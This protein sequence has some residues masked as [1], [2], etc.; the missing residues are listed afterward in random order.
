M[1]GNTLRETYKHKTKMIRPPRKASCTSSC[2]NT[3]QIIIINVLKAC[4]KNKPKMVYI[5]E[6]RRGKKSTVRVK[7]EKAFK[8]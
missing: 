1:K 5:T 3:S 6:K 8:E 7:N 4:F 2:S